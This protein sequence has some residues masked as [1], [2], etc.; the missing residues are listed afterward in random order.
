[1]S[2]NTPDSDLPPTIDLPPV[3][4]S[5]RFVRALETLADGYRS[6]LPA[7]VANMEAANARL[8]WQRA[9]FE[10]LL[11]LARAPFFE[12][13][14]GRASLRLTPFSLATSGGI[15]VG[16]LSLAQYLNVDEQIADLWSL[17]ACIA[18]EP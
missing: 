8:A 15:I 10:S 12:L 16:L 11:S 3:S 7:Y 17:A 9:L 5:L 6:M 1:M 4:E 14:F 13:D 18:T 2:G